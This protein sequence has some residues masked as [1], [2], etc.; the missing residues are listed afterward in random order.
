VFQEVIQKNKWCSSFET[1][2]KCVTYASH[3]LKPT[4]ITPHNKKQPDILQQ[5]RVKLQKNKISRLELLNILPVVDDISKFFFQTCPVF[6]T[7]R[8][9]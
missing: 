6:S 8:R 7:P 3:H 1:Q 4:I 5:T 2:C 9:V